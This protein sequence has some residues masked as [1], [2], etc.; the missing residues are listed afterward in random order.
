M[1]LSPNSHSLLQASKKLSLQQRTLSPSRVVQTQQEGLTS[2]ICYN[3]YSIMLDPLC[4]SSSP[5]AASILTEPLVTVRKDCLSTIVAKLLNASTFHVND[6]I[7]VGSIALAG[8]RLR[9]WGV[10]GA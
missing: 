10:R 8:M 6:V 3:S 9:Q 5:E 1:T 2:L 7:G 4:S